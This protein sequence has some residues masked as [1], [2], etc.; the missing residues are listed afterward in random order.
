MNDILL[1]TTNVVDGIPI[2]RYYGLITANQVAGTGLFTDMMA[3]FSD[4]FGGNSGAYRE[5]MNTLYKDVT[6]RLKAKAVEVGANAVIG[7]SI[8]YDSI[9]AKSMS[10]F[11]ISIQG[12]AVKLSIPNEHNEIFTEKGISWDI[13]HAEY[14]KKKI[15]R[16]L[17]ENTPLLGDEWAF[18][19]KNNTQE[20]LEPLYN[21]Y[22]LCANESTKDLDYGSGTIYTGAQR[23]HW[24]TNGVEN[25]KKYLSTLDYGNAI[26]YAYRDLSAFMEIIKQNKL[27]NAGKILQIAKEG[28]ID[29]AI[30]L[31][32]IEKSSYNDNDLNE[33]KSLYEYL[34]NLPEKGK[35][36]DVKGGLFSSGGLRFIC[37]CG[38]KNDLDIEF[39]TNCGNNIYGLT[40]EQVVEIEK[41]GE[42]VETLDILL[43]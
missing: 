16:K 9:S 32:F 28:D 27:F 29:S 11:M 23:A 22:I 42:L 36:E 40:R 2:E 38:C 17:N 12:T 7:V 1:L 13:L 19:I 6:E 33:M 31:L 8:D 26:K 20:L 3:S 43:K 41:F 5:S 35:K 37:S 21:Y 10:M 25:Y 14:N 4:L 30:S 34:T 18:I 24:A 39:C 15:L